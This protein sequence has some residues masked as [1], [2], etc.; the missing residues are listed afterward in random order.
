MGAN[1]IY[2][3]WF[4]IRNCLSWAYH[5]SLHKAGS[6]A[7][8]IGLGVIGALSDYWGL[9]LN[10]AD[11]WKGSLSSSSI[12]FITAWLLVFLCKLIYIAIKLREFP[13][14]VK[15]RTGKGHPFQTLEDFPNHIWHKC[16]VELENRGHEEIYNCQ[17][18]IELYSQ[19]GARNLRF[20]LRPPFD[21]KP[22]SRTL[23]NV[24][25]VIDRKD[26]IINDR[27]AINISHHTGGGFATK[28]SILERNRPHNVCLIIEAQGLTLLRLD[29]LIA[30]EEQSLVVRRV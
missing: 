2:D 14:W 6:V 26:G 11:D 3:T 17:P 23:I 5:D 22:R 28:E 19:S 15:V 1:R 12:Y 24:A 10:F 27:S 8:T 9:Q 30:M 21:M 16:F 20:G 18:I 29:C 25:E 4:Y 13:N 7:G